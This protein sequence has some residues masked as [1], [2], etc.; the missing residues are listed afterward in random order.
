MA[1]ENKEAVLMTAEEKAQF[2]AFR[3]EHAK[4][5]AQ[6]KAKSGRDAYKS[7]VDEAINS[8]FPQLQEVSKKLAKE[9][10]SV[11]YTFQKA[12][13]MKLDLFQNR[14]DNLSHTFTNGEGTRRIT[15]GYY[16]ED[17]YR[18]TVEDGIAMIKEVIESLAKDDESRMLVNA[19]LK[20][21]SRDKEG[22]LKASRVLQLRKMAE[23]LSNDRF[24]EGVRIIE[25][26]YQP[27][28]SKQYVRA[29]YKDE[30]GKWVTVP[31]G[32][33]ES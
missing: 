4:K 28:R 13:D 24:A 33:T 1:T 10:K 9:K 19:I 14:S 29:E 26:S 30:I 25:E 22:N 18:D 17:G 5:I 16:V 7:L 8:C 20:L 31:L 21:L 23:E 15:L 12:L 32:M 11:M 27:S 6:E 2:E 3:K